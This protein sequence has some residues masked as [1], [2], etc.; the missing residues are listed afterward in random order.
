MCSW[1]TENGWLSD[2]I[3]NMGINE[4]GGS[5]YLG[6]GGWGKGCGVSRREG[7]RESSATQHRRLLNI[8]GY[9][10]SSVTQ[11]CQPRPW[12]TH[13]LL[14]I[15]NYK[16]KMPRIMN[17]TFARPKLHNQSTRIRHLIHQQFKKHKFDT[18]YSKI[19]KKSR[20]RQLT[21][22]KWNVWE[23]PKDMRPPPSLV[24]V[25]IIEY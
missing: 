10:T 3:N 16:Y 15:T 18:W 21:H 14:D 2:R 25:L 1:K 13:Q 19:A 17:F 20:I 4:A 12:L 22:Q 11:H 5:A 7:V 9:S 8:V 24:S 23:H 6:K